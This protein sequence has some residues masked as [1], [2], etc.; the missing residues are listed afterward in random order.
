MPFWQRLVF[1]LIVIVVASFLAGLIWHRIFNFSLPSYVG[2]V[3]GGPLLGI[4]ETH[5]FAKKIAR[6]RAME[7][8]DGKTRRHP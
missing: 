5:G 8:R 6:L 4:I 2:G 7:S 3:I 1:T